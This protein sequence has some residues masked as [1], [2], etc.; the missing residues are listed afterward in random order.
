MFQG[1]H[2]ANDEQATAFKPDRGR[3]EGRPLPVAVFPFTEVGEA[4]QV[5]RE[6][7]HSEGNMVALWRF[8]RGG[9]HRPP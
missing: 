6:N 2:F 4:H 5:M 8:S 3:R 7:R 1:S 9:P